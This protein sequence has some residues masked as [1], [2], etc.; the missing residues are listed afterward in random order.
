MAVKQLYI[1]SGRPAVGR[2][3]IQLGDGR[4]FS[5]AALQSEL[6]RLGLSPTELGLDLLT[7]A[8]GVYFADAVTSRAEWGDDGWTRHLD[9][10]AEVHEPEL[11]EGLTD[12]LVRGLNFVSSDR[13]RFRFERRVATSEQMGFRV[14]EQARFETSRITLLSGG[15][16]SAIGALDALSNGSNLMAASISSSDT[17]TV[18]GPQNRIRGILEPGFR[19]VF[20]HTKLSVRAPQRL[21]HQR[22]PSQRA[23]SFLFL[24]FAAFL[25]SC[26]RRQIELIVPENG[27]IA[28]NVPLNVN[29]LGSNSTKTAHPYFLRRFAE[30]L[31]GAEFDVVIREPYRFLTKGEMLQQ[32]AL[33]QYLERIVCASVSCAKPPNREGT[34]ANHCGCCPA[35]IIRRAAIRAG[36]NLADPTDYHT[37]PDLFGHVLDATAKEGKDIRAFKAAAQRVTEHPSN[38]SIDI[39]RSGPMVDVH[40]HLDEYVSVY[41]RGMAEV[42]S[43]LER[44][45]TRA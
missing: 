39:F 25:A 24:S 8:L 6:R 12:I 44:V 10:V 33:P 5:F 36:Y 19:G 21:H 7:V 22:E 45:R 28:L 3:S 17:R 37:V 1:G 4:D 42:H 26:Y 40:D 23:R 2:T 41:Q 27:L 38:A 32:C 35:C 9:V 13:W 18:G 34:A 43:L 20:A 30:L 31:R 29:R 16:D 11:W 14:I 15:L